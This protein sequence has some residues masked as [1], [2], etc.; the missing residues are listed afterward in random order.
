MQGNGTQASPY[1][2][3]TPQDLHSV[4]N[5][6]TAYYELANDIDMASFGNFTPIG[7]AIPYFTGHFD[8]KGYKVKN[9]TTNETTHNSGLFG[10]VENG[11]VKNLGVENALITSTQYRNGVIV[12]YLIGTGR[13]ENCFSTG[14]INGYARNGGI[15]GDTSGGTVINCY[16]HASVN[17]SDYATG[18]IVG[19]GSSSIYIENCY[20]TGLITSDSNSSIGGLIGS[21]GST[22]SCINSYWDKET[23]G[24]SIS[25]GG[26]GLTTTQM[27]TQSSYVGWDFTNTWGI[28]NDYPILQV[29]GVELPPAKIETINVTSHVNTIQTLSE[30]HI[31]TL[32]KIESYLSPIHSSVQKSTRSVRSSTQTVTSFINPISASVERQSK[33]FIHLLSH[34]KP[35][36]ADLSV[37]YPVSNK[38]VNGYVSVLENPSSVSTMDN[39]SNVSYIVNP[40]SLE[41]IE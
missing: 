18:G 23:S 39:M 17:S 41:V 30:R 31:A 25:A 22:G 13:I 16:S 36:R 29:F 14:Q 10:V 7:K 40:S 28:N 5:N 20:S 8:G 4:R 37:L 33:T 2:L 1:L 19:D 21:L 11:I 26:T 15:V 6:L 27:K 38:V 12:G 34:L 32:R 24:Q 35:F 9:L 3:S